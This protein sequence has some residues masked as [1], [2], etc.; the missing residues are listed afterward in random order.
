ME[1]PENFSFLRQEEGA[2]RRDPRPAPPLPSVGQ[3]LQPQSRRD[4]LGEVKVEG[5]GSL[6]LSTPTVPGAPWCSLTIG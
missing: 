6:S 3:R 2:G 5:Q 4:S 1:G